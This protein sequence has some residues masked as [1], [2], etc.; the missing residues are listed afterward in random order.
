MSHL[1]E[2]IGAYITTMNL[3]FSRGASLNTTDFYSVLLTGFSIVQHL[4]FLSELIAKLVS[5]DSKG[6]SSG[7]KEARSSFTVSGNYSEISSMDSVKIC[8]FLVLFST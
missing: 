8:S 5:F 2:V 1:E 6:K 3:L 7:Q 4:N